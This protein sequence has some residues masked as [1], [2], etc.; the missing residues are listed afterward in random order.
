MLKRNKGKIVLSLTAILVLFCLAFFTNTR[1][2]AAGNTR[3]RIHATTS[4]GISQL[5]VVCDVGNGTLIYTFAAHGANGVA[6]ALVP[7]GC[8]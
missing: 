3:L 7:N 6:I 4:V 5:S 1:A 8:S 2:S